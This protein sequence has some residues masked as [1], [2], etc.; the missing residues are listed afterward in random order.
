MKSN[1]RVVILISFFLV[2]LSVGSSISYYVVSMNSMEKQLR[3]Q[4]LPLSIDN[5]YTDIQKHIIEPYLVSSMMASDTFMHD[6]LVNEEEDVQK[7]QRYLESI[8]NRYGML[9]AFLVSEK[10]QN[11]YTQNGLIEKIKKE[12]PVNQWYFTF[13]EMQ[14]NH[15]IN[16]DLNDNITDSVI[17][18][19]NFKILDESFHYLGATG[20]G[21]KISYINEML[22]MFKNRYNLKVSFLDKDGNIILSESHKYGTLE[23]IDSVSGYSKLKARILSND[24]NLMEYSLNGSNYLVKTKYVKE[25]D[26]HL[27]VEANLDDFIQDTKN[28]FYINLLI[29]LSL[30]V[31]IALIIVNIVKNYNLKLERLADHDA[32]TSIPNRR[33]FTHNLQQYISLNKRMQS[34]LSLAFIDIDDFKKVNDNFGHT[35]GDEVL[36]E[37][38]HTIE[39]YTRESDLCARWGGEEFVIAFMNTNTNDAEKIIEKIRNILLNNL[40]LKNLIGKSITISTGLTKYSDSDTIDSIISRADDAMYQAKQSGKNCIKISNLE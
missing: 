5:I 14:E 7:I 23:N 1:Y 26:I 17:M 39:S 10:S 3:T 20:V 22:K 12:N 16:L 21:I 40:R 6:W 19:I 27:L 38:A 18:F 32:L 25:L 34:S 13:K 33:N 28:N 8:K 36:K 9:V 31:I 24:I 4:S 37:V 2:V 29:S 15:E 11:Y 35:I 30:T